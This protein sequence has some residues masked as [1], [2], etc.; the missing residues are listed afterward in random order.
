[1][2][3]HTATARGAD[4]A[5]SRSVASTFRSAERRPSALVLMLRRDRI[6]A[7]ALLV[8]IVIVALALLAPTL[9]LS[10]PTKAKFSDKLLPPLS[11]GHLLGTDQLG[12]DMMSRLIWGARVSLTVGVVAALLA[13]TIGA[14]IG[15]VAGY[16]GGRLD[17]LIMRLIDIMLAFPYILLAIAL[18]A[19]L[20]P[21]LVNAM[22][23]IAVANISFYARNMRGNVLTLRNQA[24]IEAALAAG[25]THRRILAR[26]ILPNLV[27][28]L[29]VLVSMNVGWMITETAGLSFLGLGAQ[30][31][32]AD[33]GSMLADGR[34][35]ITV[36]YHVATIPG[37][38][39][40]ILVL[41]LNILGD[42]L[43][44]ALD[45]RLRNR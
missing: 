18:V 44:D 2:S 31:P 15:I 16:L 42:S 45:P 8:V 43:R 22:L 12:R 36:A 34:Q 5:L 13:S 20:G 28:P 23:A 39:I 33:W 6:A 9:P 11:S 40:L 27:P 37:M 21:G 26:H 19:A 10:S 32:T 30:P 7:A 38:M 35:F 3:D 17:N 24:Y 29:L 14:L 25:A 1:M 4:R 41:A